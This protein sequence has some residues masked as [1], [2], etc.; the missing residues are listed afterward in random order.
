MRNG[1]V[2][3]TE[4]LD[5]EHMGKCRGTGVLVERADGWKLDFYSLSF[6][7]PN[8][9]VGDLVELATEERMAALKFQAELDAHYKDP[10]H[11]PLSEEDRKAFTGHQ[12]YPVDLSYRVEATL[13]LTPR[14]KPFDMATTSGKS[15]KYRKYADLSFTLHGI[16]HRIPVYQSLRLMEMEG[17]EN[18]LF[19]PFRDR[20]SGHETYGTGRFMDLEIPSE[21]T[22][23][24]LDFNTAYNP[25]CAYSDGYSC[26]ITPSENFIDADIRAG[27]K[28]PVDGH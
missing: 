11:S 19:L 2:H 16:T 24:I 28:G 27:I 14:S 4:R 12:F 15:R 1:V 26:P 25:Y 18:H 17:Y 20:T 5:S 8:E 3:F 23:V 6:E 13:D 9:I 21:G 7:V 22:T 10:E